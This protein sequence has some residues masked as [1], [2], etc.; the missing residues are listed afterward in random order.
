MA[1]CPICKSVAEEIEPGFFDGKTFRCPKHNEFEVT[2]SALKTQAN[3][4]ADQWEAAYKRA[5]DK[6]AAGKRPRIS[7]YSF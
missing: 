1:T 4:T 3:D 7:H 2:D 6:A 5:K